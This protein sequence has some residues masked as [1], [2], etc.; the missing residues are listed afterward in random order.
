[1][2]CTCRDQADFTGSV[3]RRLTIRGD[4]TYLITGG[5]GG[6]GLQSAHWLVAQGARQIVLMGRSAPSSAAQA[7]LDQLERLGGHV[8]V[9]QADVSR[10]D[11]VAAVLAE[12]DPATPLRGVIHAAGAL[13]DGV[14]VQ[15][16]DDRFESGLAAKRAGAQNLHAGTQ[17]QP[18]DFFV[19]FSSIASV[20][21]SIGQG[22]YAAA[23]AYLD[24]LAHTRRAQGL[25]GLSINW[26]PWS[27]VGMAAALSRHDQDRRRAQGLGFLTPV[28]GTRAL[29]QA[30]QQDVAQLLVLPIDWRQHVGADT[31]PPL[32]REVA[33]AAPIERAGA[34]AP[35]IDVAQQVIA[36]APINAVRSWGSLCVCTRLK[37]WAWA[38][39]TPFDPRRPL[40]E[41]GLDSLMAVELRN[42]LGASLKRTL[43]ATLLFDYPTLETLTDF[44]LKE[45]APS[46]PP[47]ASAP[48]IPDRAVMAA[49]ELALLSEAEAEALLLAE[50]SAG[51]PRKSS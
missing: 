41:L 25:P 8:I 22:S 49:A 13:A 24:A 47:A 34:A 18:L 16:T 51:K 10:A 30:L 26:G 12:I 42:A 15:Q 28:Q 45:L 43:P 14:L 48:A 23:N 6:L 33:Q 2:P 36:A 19:M 3:P 31:V 1:M 20:F 39:H 27:E 50:L 46:Q 37:C 17:D 11:Q 7:A 44:L 32:L 29:A 38:P 4:A 9:A 40:S 5:L 21:G 35:T